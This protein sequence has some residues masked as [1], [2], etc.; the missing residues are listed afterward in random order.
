MMSKVLEE[1]GNAA[2]V[3]VDTYRESSSSSTGREGK[4][5]NA[6]LKFVQESGSWKVD[7]IE[8]QGQ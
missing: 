7:Q 2:S 3:L 1:S 5:E 6:L 8:W 4:Y